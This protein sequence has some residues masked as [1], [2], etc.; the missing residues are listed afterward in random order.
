MKKLTDKRPKGNP[1]I[2]DNF[3][4][5]PNTMSTKRSNALK[6]IQKILKYGVTDA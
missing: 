2:L 6:N 1:A 3:L 5:L 4:I